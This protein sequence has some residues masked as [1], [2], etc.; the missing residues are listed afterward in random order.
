M[1]KAKTLSL[2]A[3]LVLVSF[4]IYRCRRGNGSNFAL[5]DWQAMKLCNGIQRVRATIPL[6]TSLKNL[7]YF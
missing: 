3:S 2:L 5:L 7:V 6:K 4:C 1:T